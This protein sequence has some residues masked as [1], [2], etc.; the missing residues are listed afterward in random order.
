MPTSSRRLL[1]EQIV[2]HDFML[3]ILNFSGVVHD[4]CVRLVTVVD[5]PQG[6]CSIQ[7]VSS[8]SPTISGGYIRV[9]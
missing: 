1:A 5:R 8:N 2:N 4:C 6:E 9:A 7:L 3:G